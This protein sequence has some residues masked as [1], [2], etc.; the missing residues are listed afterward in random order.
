MATKISSARRMVIVAGG[1]AC[2]LVMGVAFA[3]WTQTGT[4]TGSA[5]A[6]Q[7]APST[8]AVDSATAD[9]YPGFDGGDL[10]FKVDNP[11]PYPVRFTS[12]TAGAVTSSNPTGCP[13]SNATVANKSGLSIDVPANTTTA[14]SKTIADVVTLASNAPNACQGV[15]FSINVTLSGAQQ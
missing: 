12:M 11:N 15:T 1:V 2:A 13:E 5:K 3:L 7:A 8:V 10:Y 4:G 14:V 9:L 6:L